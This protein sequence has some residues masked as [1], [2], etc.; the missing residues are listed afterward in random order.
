[1][2]PNQTTELPLR[3]IHLPE[4][5]SWWPPAPGW[6]LL[7]LL[8]ALL[9]FS[10]W[11]LKKL[12]HKGK[13]KRILK[14]S[15]SGAFSTIRSDFV[16]SADQSKLIRDL[17]T[18]MRRIAI[19]L[20]PRADVAGL[21]AQAWLEFLDK[22]GDETAFTQGPGSILSHGPYQPLTEAFDAEVLLQLCEAWARQAMKMARNRSDSRSK[23]HV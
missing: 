22:T 23:R 16:D 9:L 8:I 7:P 21:T 2:Q 13:Q 11:A 1:M 17:S 6:W 14:L 15:I 12:L 5:V 4:A 20:Y 10:G 3:D 19:S 18:L